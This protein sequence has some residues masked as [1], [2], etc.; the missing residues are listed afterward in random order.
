MATNRNNKITTVL[1]YHRWV[2]PFFKVNFKVLESWDATAH[3]VGT[4]TGPFTRV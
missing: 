3:R 2:G 1:S 4:G